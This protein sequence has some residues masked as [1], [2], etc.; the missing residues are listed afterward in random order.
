MSANYRLVRNPNPRPEASGELQPL[1]PR[2]VSNGTIHTNDLIAKASARSSFS[3]ADMKGVLQLFHEMIADYLMS[4]YNVELEG[5]GTFSISLKSRP[6]MDKKEIRAE[7]IHFKDVK[8]RSSKKLRDCLKTM[9]VFRAEYEE[10]DKNYVSAKECEERLFR[11]LD[12]HP[13]ILSKEYMSLCRCR[14]TKATT[15]LRKLVESGRLGWRRIGTTRIYYKVEESR[16]G[17]GI[18]K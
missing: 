18:P 1:H 7:S 2:L 3:S 15:D 8:Y 14:K 4:G 10:S 5:I 13:Y 17:E 16:E 11:Y 9:P 6:T 12:T